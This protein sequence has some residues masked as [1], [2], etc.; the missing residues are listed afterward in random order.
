MT[1]WQ[2]TIQDRE[3]SHGSRKRKLLTQKGC[4][5]PFKERF[6]C[7]KQQW[8][9]KEPCPFINRRECENFSTMSGERFAKTQ[10]Y[11]RAK[12]KQ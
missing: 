3:V 7:P 2:F 9:S 11:S 6:W 4:N 1:I 8:F 12:N 5:E 10:D